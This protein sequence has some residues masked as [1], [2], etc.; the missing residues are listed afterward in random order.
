MQFSV[1]HV[2]VHVRVSSWSNSL[3][4]SLSIN[5]Y[6]RS[7]YLHSHTAGHGRSTTRNFLWGRS[8]PNTSCRASMSRSRASWMAGVSS[9]YISQETTT[10][11]AIMNASWEEFCIW[12]CWWREYCPMRESWS[13]TWKESL[14]S[15]RLI[16]N[17]PSGKCS[18]RWESKALWIHNSQFSRIHSQPISI[19]LIKEND[20]IQAFLQ[21][22]IDEDVYIGIPQG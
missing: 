7:L 10:T 22:P 12:Q 3:T 2:V 19:F 18:R 13:H 17:F 14:T 9:V 8:C 4:K 21:A 11:H 16:R 6:S 1:F 20:F 15:T 5:F